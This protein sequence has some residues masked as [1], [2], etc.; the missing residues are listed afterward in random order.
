MHGNIQNISILTRQDSENLRFNRRKPGNFYR[1]YHQLKDIHSL[2]MKKVDVDFLQNI[3]LQVAE[4]RQKV[5]ER[6]ATVLSKSQ[7]FK[8]EVYKR[9]DQTATLCKEVELLERSLEFFAPRSLISSGRSVL[10]ISTS[11]R[12]ESESL[13][14]WV[15][16][17]SQDDCDWVMQIIDEA[18][19]KELLTH[20]FGNY[21]VQRLLER[22]E[23]F[24]RQVGKVCLESP[25]TFIQFATN[26]YSSRVLQVLVGFEAS[27]SIEVVSLLKARLSVVA[28][29]ASA[30]FL[31]TATLKALNKDEHFLFIIEN[32]RQRQDYWLGKRFFKRILVSLI[33][34]SNEKALADI[35]LSISGIFSNSNLFE[36]KYSVFIAMAFLDRRYRP[37][38]MALTALIRNRLADIVLKKEFKYFI[39]NLANGTYDSISRAIYSAINEPRFNHLLSK[40]ANLYKEYIRAV[41]VPVTE[42]EQQ[43]PVLELTLSKAE[44]TRA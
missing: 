28:N 8:I 23:V 44:K 32:L 36:D 30:T 27:L 29:N 1:I 15:K 43:L 35:F 34:F 4:Q 11:C 16:T 22:S 20:K 12:E 5:L 41:C 6:F 24:R 17:C 9:K 13:Q 7:M 26:E 37:A 25:E 40:E 38:E 21:V 18:T 14:L 10:E 39:A 33:K 19:L 31:L 2:P 42:W 3:Q